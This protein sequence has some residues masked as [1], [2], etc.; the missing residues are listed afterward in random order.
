[1]KYSNKN[2]GAL[3]KN[4]D[5]TNERQP[6][7][8]GVINVEGKDFRLAVW[9][10]NENKHPQSPA[11][12]LQVETLQAQRQAPPKDYAETQSDDEFDDKLP[13]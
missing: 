1:M 5:K 7:Y 2:R 9:I 4:D 3:W 13:F 10:N 8:R 6:D 12:T 11:M